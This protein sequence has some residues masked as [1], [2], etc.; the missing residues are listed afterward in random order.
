MPAVEKHEKRLKE[1]FTDEFCDEV[2]GII[3]KHDFNL[4][5]LYD[6]LDENG[7]MG[8]L[9][10]V[11]TESEKLQKMF[12]EIM[13]WWSKNDAVV[14]EFASYLPALTTNMD[15]GEVRAGPSKYE[16]MH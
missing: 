4:P 6:K 13:G 5:K 14:T 3:D 8:Y 9:S 2:I 15:T 10:L 12:E 7:F 16:Q 1:I 11:L